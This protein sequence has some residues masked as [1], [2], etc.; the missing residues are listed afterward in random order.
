M[1]N[2][3]KGG[4]QIN[5]IHFSLF[6]AAGLAVL[7]FVAYMDTRPDCTPFYFGCAIPSEENKRWQLVAEWA[8]AYLV[9][10]GA[11]YALSQLLGRGRLR[12]FLRR[13]W[14]G[15]KDGVE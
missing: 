4:G 10:G 6:I 9:V 8:T 13:F 1:R 7:A 5:W 14:Y 3:G 15:D 2:T 12:R 11:L